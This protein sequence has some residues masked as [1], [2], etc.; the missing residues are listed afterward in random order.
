MFAVTVIF[1]IHTEEMDR[2]MPLMLENATLSLHGEAGCHQFDV[3]TDPCRPNEVFLYE[4]YTDAAA[5]DVHLRSDHFKHFTAETA[6]MIAAK[7][8][9]TYRAVQQ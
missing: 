3:C 9:R 5:F 8:V 6:P 1:D 4:L 7:K 2:F